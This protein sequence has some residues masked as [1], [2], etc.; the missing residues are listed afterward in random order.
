MPQIETFVFGAFALAVLGYLVWYWWPAEKAPAHLEVYSKGYRSFKGADDQD[1][2]IHVH[3]SN[4]SPQLRKALAVGAVLSENNTFPTNR[5]ETGRPVE[6]MQAWLAESWSVFS[7]AHARKEIDHLFAEGHRVV[8]DRVAAL[9]PT[10]STPELAKTLHVE[11]GNRFPATDLHEFAQ[12]FPAVGPT[13][14]ELG[15]LAQPQDLAAFGALAYD[16]GRAV[17]VS[18]VAASAGYLDTTTAQAYM[19]EALRITE[20]TFP[21]WGSFAASYL[22]GRALWGGVDDPSFPTMNDMVQMLLTQPESPW[23]E[24]P[25]RP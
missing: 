10:M 13:L 8:L 2:L 17:T 3:N 19:M 15:H 1:Y 14:V 11:F 9:G 22:A 16:I 4:A 12:N 21:T 20:S 25:L 6:E 24:F 23:Q 5:I 7:E 18:R